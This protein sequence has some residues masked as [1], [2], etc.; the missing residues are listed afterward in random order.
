LHIFTDK[1]FKEKSGHVAFVRKIDFILVTLSACHDAQLPF[2]CPVI[3]VCAC[4]LHQ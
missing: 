2:C 4:Y 3:V 1:T